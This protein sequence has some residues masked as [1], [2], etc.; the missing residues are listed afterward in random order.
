LDLRA[1]Q[2]EAGPAYQEL[3]EAVAG[4]KR[5]YDLHP[6]AVRPRDGLSLRRDAEREAV[7]ELVKDFREL[8]AEQRRRMPALL[9]S[10]GQLEV[11]VG[12]LE[13]GQRDFE[14]AAG[15]VADPAA[16]AEAH[17]NVYRAALERRDWEEALAA[18]RRAVELDPAAFA[19]F[20]PDRYEP[21]RILG[22]GGFGTTFLCAE[23]PGGRR[24][25][26][27]ALRSDS[28]DRDVDT[29]FREA[30]LLRELDHPV[31]A[32]LRESGRA[33]AD[34]E[35]PFLVWDYFDG[36]T[37]GAYV[38]RH[39]PLPPA[40]W[41]EVAW[42]L[43]RA[44]QAA[45]GGGVLHRSLRPGS[46]LVRREQ[47]GDGPPRWR[48]LL[49][50]TGL[51]LKRALIHAAASHPDARA[52]TALGRCVAR[53]V[54]FAPPE[55][56]GKPKGQVWV[57]PH[58]DVYG[59]GRLCAFAL[60]GRPDPAE[61]AA[62]LPDGWRE[63]VADCTAWVPARRP[64]DFGAVLDRLAGLAGAGDVV[65]RLDRQIH[66]ITVAEH[67]AALEADPGDVAALAARGNAYARQGDHAR[68]AEDFTRALALR[69]DDAGLWRRRALA[70]QQ[71]GDFEK[72]AD[73]YTEALKR[74]PHHLEAHANRGL[75]NA[76]REDFGA[77]V[78]DFAEAIR[79]NP[80]DPALYYNRGNAHFARG[81]F[82]LAAADYSEAVR[83]D[84]GHAW[85]FG[86][87][88]RAYARLGEHAR[89]A[90]D[91]GR[92]IQIDPQNARA[93]ADRAAAHLALGRPDRAVADYTEA[94]RLEPEFVAAWLGR[95]AAHVA[96]GAYEPAV[97]D[98][99]EALR[100]RPGDVAALH[101][102]GRLHA[103]H[104]DYGRALADNLEAERLDPENARTLN[105]LAWLWATAPADQGRDVAKALEYARK[106]CE[107]T[108]SADA[109]A[110]DTLAV[111]CAA[112]GRF[113]E[114]A[115]WQRK[116]VELA[117]EADKEDYRTRLALYEAGQPYRPTP[118][119]GSD[120]GGGE[121]PP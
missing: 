41:L 16:R 74:E 108:G 91:F 37:L 12:D 96:A 83:R 99:A 36:Q 6:S 67:T 80:R 7:Q 62:P 38:A 10:L 33:G 104:G 63:L 51:G 39:G 28:L 57:G 105:N 61:D 121:S 119:G 14:E 1:E 46:V 24:A 22:A 47:E 18:L 54:P 110:L 73:D 102:R 29:L 17:H 106:A 56:V 94:V 100:L 109:G 4:L 55:V 53:L 26:V 71:A 49:L 89:A 84:P 42:P 50:D 48:V 60:V 45:H 21:D 114:A 107:L 23:K 101:A 66:E 95:A 52:R 8:P 68:A 44:L 58:S 86:N 69:A 79:L 117:P 120:T 40:E 81:D 90:A 25:V 85:A 82:D 27:L 5:R 3:Y 116:A 11:V 19:P 15:L 112:A 77:A 43:A 103:L 13:E 2:S 76:R 20:P 70:Y 118:A 75:V 59:F 65:E 32:R 93:F 88:G 78:A 92:V 31:P 87:R 9:N 113:E 111:A 98:Y 34:G 35:R 64:P 97:A 72:A 30:A 115:D